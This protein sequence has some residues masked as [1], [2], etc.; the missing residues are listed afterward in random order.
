MSGSRGP[1]GPSGVVPRSSGRCSATTPPNAARGRYFPAMGH[2][3]KV[4]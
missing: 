1:A 4:T 2:G 3:S